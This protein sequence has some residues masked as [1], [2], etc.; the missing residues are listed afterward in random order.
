ML[1]SF[2]LFL[3][4]F[5]IKN[6]I[7]ENNPNVLNIALTLGKPHY[8]NYIISN[9]NF[10][11][12]HYKIV[13]SS[14]RQ[15]YPTQDKILTIVSDPEDYERI[16]MQEHFQI[17]NSYDCVNFDGTV[18]IKEN[19]SIPVVFKLLSYDMSVKSHYPRHACM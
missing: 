3:L 14:N 18:V 12:E 1:I 9:Q 16:T 11:D 15:P 19:E 13:I 5:I 7:F 2:I 6:T 17:P 4:G 10:H 8:F